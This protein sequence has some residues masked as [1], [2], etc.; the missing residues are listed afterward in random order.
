MFIIKWGN[1]SS[2]RKQRMGNAKSRPKPLP[3]NTQNLKR[4][5]VKEVKASL[6]S[7]EETKLFDVNVSAATVGSGGTITALSNM[8]QGVGVRQRTGDDVLHKSISLTYQLVQLN[9]DIYSDTRIIVFEW[10]PNTG[11]LVPVLADI[12]DN[13]AAIGLYSHYTWDLRD[14]YKILYDKIHSLSGLTTA[15]TANSNVNVLNHKIRLPKVK[16]EYATA[17]TT[18]SKQIYSL[19][20]SDS[21]IAPFPVISWTSRY[22]YTDA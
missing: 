15:P 2:F 17:A 20:I 7:Q 4:E 14:Q 11:L 3:N 8:A 21:A 6:A 1:M 19:W 22:N 9:A 18:G 12:L 13:T 10:M 5:I 16:A